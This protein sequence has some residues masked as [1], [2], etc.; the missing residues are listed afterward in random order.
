MTVT[1]RCLASSFSPLVNRVTTLLF[2][3]RRRVAVN[4][5]SAKDD[6]IGRHVGRVFD[7]L[8]GMQQRLGWNAA[9]V[10]ADPAQAWANAR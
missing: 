4:P 1:L 5:R 10:Q 2:Q 3:A 9:N 8:G 6:A 7:D